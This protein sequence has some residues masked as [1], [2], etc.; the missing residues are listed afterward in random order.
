MVEKQRFSISSFG[1]KI[2]AILMMTLDH[3]GIFLIERYATTSAQYF[4]GEI[5]RIFGRIAFPLFALMLAEGMFHSKH[6]EKYLARLFLV[7]LGITLFQVITTYG[8]K[9]VAKVDVNFQ[10]PFTDLVLNGLVLYFLTRK[11]KLKILALIP[12]AITIGMTALS[13]YESIYSKTIYWLPLMFRSSYGI[14]GLL[15]TLGFFY[16]RPIAKFLLTKQSEDLG[17]SDET[18]VNSILYS[19]L[20]NI[21]SC[22]LFFT[23]NVIFYVIK[24]YPEIGPRLDIIGMSYSYKHIS[25]FQSYAIL[26]ILPIMLYNGKR[27][28]DSKFFRIFSYLFFPLHLFIIYLIFEFAL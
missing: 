18:L 13:T 10:N 11:N 15:I 6:K 8:L 12:A 3:I 20:I 9:G 28:Y 24:Y 4:T 19:R 5:F 27:G 21:V 16:A 2:I 22:V 7:Y 23:I 26:A 17:M 14:Y 1:L 25:G